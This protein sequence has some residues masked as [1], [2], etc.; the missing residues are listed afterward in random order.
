MFGRK[1]V[2]FKIIECCVTDEV[3]TPTGINTKNLHEHIG[4]QAK[5]T[6][7]ESTGIAAEKTAFSQRNE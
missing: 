7:E 2:V 6:D 4:I 1:R 5:K 3:R